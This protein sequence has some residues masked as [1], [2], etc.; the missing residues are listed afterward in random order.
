MF[1]LFHMQC[2]QRKITSV[3]H[4][5]CNNVIYLIACKNCLEQYIG[6]ATNFKNRFRVRKSDIKTNK[7]RCR[8]AKHFNAE[9]KNDSN[10][11]QF[12]SVQII[13][14]VYGNATDIAEILWHRRNYWQSQ[15]FTATHGMN[16]LRYLCC[17][18][19]KEYRK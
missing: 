6:S 16:S 14:Q 3:L 13:E 18:K 10:I 9:C 1:Q 5:N 12:L 8:V 19:R 4:C 7:G 15:L 11:F 2:H 17:Y